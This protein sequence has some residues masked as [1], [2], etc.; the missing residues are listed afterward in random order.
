MFDIA[1]TGALGHLLRQAGG[2]QVSSTP[3]TLALPPIPQDVSA[4]IQSIASTG[5]CSAPSARAVSVSEVCY[6]VTVSGT[7]HETP[8]MGD[9]GVYALL[10]FCV[11]SMSPPPIQPTAEQTVLVWTVRHM[12]HEPADRVHLQHSYPDR[13]VQLAHRLQVACTV[14]QQTDN[15][16][17]V[18]AESG[19]LPSA[20][21][22]AVILQTV[23]H[24]TVF[25]PPVQPAPLIRPVALTE[26]INL[27]EIF[28]CSPAADWPRCRLEE[29]LQAVCFRYAAVTQHRPR[30]HRKTSASVHSVSRMP[31]AAAHHLALC[32]D[33]LLHFL[34][35]NQSNLMALG[36]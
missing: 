22:H 29:L 31:A 32:V 28:N 30:K 33:V 10:N 26:D 13:L 5:T 34:C 7:V 12:L 27:F 35:A 25:L 8:A 36:K 2:P 14:V 23:D 19:P 15:V 20:S 17:Y 24:Y 11:Q 21:A 4:A 9:C 16:Y 18:V 6:A 1:P 3:A